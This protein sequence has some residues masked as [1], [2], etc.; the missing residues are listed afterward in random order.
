MLKLEGEILMKKSLIA[1]AVAGA[2][3]APMLAQA[4]AT[5]YGIAEMRIIDEDNEDL[6]VNMNKTRL[7]VKGTVDNDIEGLTSFYQ[8]EW[9]FDG[10]GNLANTQA[11]DTAVRK[12]L[13]GLKGGFGSVIFGRQNAHSS[14][15][16]KTDIFKRGSG[17][18]IASNFRYGNS[19]SYVTPKMGG[20]EAYVQVV[21]DANLQGGA[22]ESEDLDLTAIGAN[23][24]ANGLGV[25]LAYTETAEE[26][27][28]TTEDREI[29]DLGVSYSMDAFYVGAYYSDI[30]AGGDSTNNFALAASYT[31]GKAVLK[32]GYDEVEVSGGD[33]QE[34]IILH[35]GYKLGAKA[36]T[37]VQYQDRNDAAGNDALSLGYQLNF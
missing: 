3:T 25:A 28:G 16:H 19:V 26:A 18:A 34:Q 14:A 35:A 36:Y 11:N 33:D 22:A 2:M 27:L 5:L 32:A 23:Y 37:Y 10:N 7:G 20:F 24:S 15:T 6:D 4:D 13:V 21:A 1:L 9:E 8:F 17:M 12:S 31:A 29:L 30:D